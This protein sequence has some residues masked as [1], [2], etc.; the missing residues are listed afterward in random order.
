VIV[1]SS[2]GKLVPELEGSGIEHFQI[3]FTGARMLGGAWALRRLLEREH[4]DLVNAHNWRAGLV[5]YLA[6][7]RAGVP[8]VLTVHGTRGPAHRYGVF[9]WSKRVVVVSEE[10]RRNLVEGFGLAAERVV[11]SMVGVDC[12]EF[13][14]MAREDSLEGELGLRAGAP[15]VVH[16]SRFSKSKARVALGLVEAMEAL[17]RGAPGVELVLVGQGP[18]EGA[19]AAAAEEMNR[20][21]GRRG[22]LALGGRGD[23]ARVLSLGDVVV[24][25]ATVALEAMACGKPVAAAGKAGY[26]GVVG[27][28]NLERAEESCFGDHGR[29]ET[30][31]PERMA[32]DVGRLLGDAE[33]RTRL[34]EFGRETV[35]ARYDAPRAAEEMEGIYR[36][37]L[38]ERE[39]VRRILVFHLNQIGDLVFTLPA[40]KA[41]REAFPEAR[42][43]SVLRPRLAG[44]VAESGFVDDIVRRPDGGPLW[45]VG[46][47]L[48]L[49]GLRP[50]L[51][52]VLSQSATMALCARLSGAKQRVGYVDSDL[53][54]L[55]NHRIQV[56]GIPC[57]EKVMRLLRGLGLAPEKTDYVGLIRLSAE[58]DAAGRRLLEECG[59]AGEG[60]RV[61]LAPG[62]AG[63]R[64]YKAWTTEGFREVASGLAERGAQVVVVGGE[65]DRALG[66]EST[67]HLGGA[68]CNLAGR[69]TPAELAGVVAR[70]D[71]LIGIDS[72]PMHVAA[73]MGTPVVALF[74]PTDPYRTGP[75]GE[76]HEVIFHRQECWR[77]CVHPV[78]P[79]CGERRCMSAITV[80]EVLGAG[81]R[82]LKRW[83]AKR[84]GV[85]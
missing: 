12:E 27:P 10:S 18:Q 8:Y 81:R 50:D 43:T 34:G 65:R 7:R 56:R 40:L 21:L 77:P 70:C 6:C 36:E 54:R 57:P 37:A 82:I 71:L 45:A 26:I 66:E 15:R 67:A 9:Y 42:I 75:Q 5:S 85:R 23:I 22:V 19:V 47:G 29:G 78:T 64:P 58:D 74:G 32:A 24:A 52:V 14:P 39:G 60:P 31:S 83:E 80:E 68:G 72:G 13:A 20:R 3:D 41:L 28:G 48:R 16:V 69:T 46:L 49:R 30:V 1:I 51:A 84:T 59:S 25:T 62:E 63:G 79:K 44:L 76:G 61:A 17:D 38:C 73:A 4:G 53:S 35:V 33:E 2:G 55:L 11:R